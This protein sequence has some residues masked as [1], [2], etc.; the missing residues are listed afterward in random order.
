MNIAAARK[1]IKTRERTMT[2]T[3]MN[4][5]IYVDRIINRIMRRS[6]HWVHHQADAA[7]K[8]HKTQTDIQHL[9]DLSAHLLRDIGMRRDEI[10]A[11]GNG[12]F[13]SG[14]L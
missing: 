10:E 12:S 4:T 7:Q 9:Q 2:T 8:E 11:K 13:N 6:I 5:P 1:H 14:N 3:T